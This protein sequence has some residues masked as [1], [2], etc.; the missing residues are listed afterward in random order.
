MAGTILGMVVALAHFAQANSVF[1]DVP[2]LRDKNC[3]SP[4][5]CLHLGRKA[6]CRDG[7]CTC[8]PDYM[9]AIHY[10]K[11][12]CVAEPTF[13]G[14][15][16]DFRPCSN[17][18]GTICYNGTCFCEDDYVFYLDRCE[19]Q[20][21]F[22]SYEE[23]FVTPPKYNIL[24]VIIIVAILIVALLFLVNKRSV[25]FYFPCCMRDTVQLA[26]VVQAEN[27]NVTEFPVRIDL[28]END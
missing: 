2:S 4:G 11:V 20:T 21:L 13:G 16:S 22:S 23:P 9:M 17:R 5:D 14:E 28:H 27:R 1:K 8:R 15:C 25:F 6:A 3:T 10:G 26:T 18:S 12:Q 7:L 24:T 19:R